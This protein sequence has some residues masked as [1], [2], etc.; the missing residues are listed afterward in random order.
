MS[1]IDTFRRHYL[2]SIVL[3]LVVTLSF[4]VFTAFTAVTPFWSMPDT[5]IPAFSN[6]VMLIIAALLELVT[7]VAIWKVASAKTALLILLWLG[8]VLLTYKFGLKEKGYDGPCKCM[9]D[10]FNKA[11]SYKTVDKIT[12]VL[13]AYMMVPSAIFLIYFKFKDH[14]VSVV[15]RREI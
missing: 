8:A 14:L 12:N 9:G 1:R 5:L 4:K 2:R 3:L 15:A 13:L 6:R 7:I 11:L 10:I